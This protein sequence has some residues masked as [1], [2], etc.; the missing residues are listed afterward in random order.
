MNENWEYVP[1]SEMFVWKGKSAIKSGDG[2]KPGTY[3]IE[4]NSVT[5]TWK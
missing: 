1:F 3:H 5:L 2:T 4:G